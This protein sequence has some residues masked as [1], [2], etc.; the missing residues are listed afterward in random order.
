MNIGLGSGDDIADVTANRALLRASLP[1]D[2]RWLHQV[3]GAAVVDAA[4]V[5][6]GARADA[7]FTDAAERRLRR[8]DRRLHA[9][10]IG[11][12]V[13][14]L[15]SVSRTPDGAASRLA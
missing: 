4:Q 6:S 12:C 14:S 13:G 7:S 11:R 10:A 5:D 3:H 8:V 2:P 15:L 1:A 9:S